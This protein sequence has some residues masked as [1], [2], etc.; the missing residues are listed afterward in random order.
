MGLPCNVGH[1]RCHALQVAAYV[2]DFS[3]AVVLRVVFGDDGR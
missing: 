2:S 3:D 1:R